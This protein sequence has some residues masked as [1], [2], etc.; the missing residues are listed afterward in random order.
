MGKG[1]GKS[2]SRVQLFATP[3][4]IQSMEFSRPE[5]W[6]G[7]FPFSRVSSQHRDQIQVSN[8]PGRFFTSKGGEI[9][10]KRKLKLEATN[11]EGRLK[12]K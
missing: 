1:K 4:T 6:S 12:S 2:L 5:Y 7:A 9:N 11:R 10:V 8:T 3:W